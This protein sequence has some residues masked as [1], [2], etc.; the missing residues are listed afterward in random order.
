M[1]NKEKDIIELEKTDVAFVL[2]KEGEISMHIPELGDEDNV[3]EYVLYVTALGVFSKDE[4]F[5][6]YVLDKFYGKLDEL[7]EDENTETNS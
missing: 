1:E 3:P 5:V 7:D 4:D 2:T 6:E